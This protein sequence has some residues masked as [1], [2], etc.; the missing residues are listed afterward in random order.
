MLNIAY[1][2]Y[3]KKTYSCKFASFE[4]YDNTA[5][6]FLSPIVGT[7]LRSTF[8]FFI[9]RDCVLKCLY[10]YIKAVYSMNLITI[11]RYINYQQVQNLVPRQITGYPIITPLLYYCWLVNGINM[12]AQ[13]VWSLQ[14][15]SSSLF[16]F[17][18]PCL[19]LSSNP[20]LPT[21]TFAF[22]LLH[23]V[24]ANLVYH[25]NLPIY[26]Y[27]HISFRSLCLKPCL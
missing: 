13:I 19:I 17:S 16:T 2:S 22:L 5:I 12:F 21:T 20:G 15:L 11:Y 6:E 27:T 3:R 25:R 26:M 8:T 14:V 1:H 4:M 9:F 7:S 23:P 18:T 10:P 24:K